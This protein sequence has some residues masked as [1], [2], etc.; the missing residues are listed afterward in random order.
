[1]ATSFGTFRV[2]LGFGLGF[3]VPETGSFQGSKGVVQ[4]FYVF[5]FRAFFGRELGEQDGGFK[6]FSN[7]GSCPSCDDG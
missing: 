4:G 2:H 6:W 7:C 3:R 5:G 1:M